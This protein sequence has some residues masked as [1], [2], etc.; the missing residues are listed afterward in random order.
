VLQLRFAVLGKGVG[1][2]FLR[3]TEGV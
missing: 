2:N 3:E 1:V